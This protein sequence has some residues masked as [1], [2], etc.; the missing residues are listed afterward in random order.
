MSQNND[1]GKTVY[2]LGAG[3]S[4]ASDFKLP[5]MKGFFD[6]EHFKEG[7]EYPNLKEFLK[8]FCPNTDWPDINLEE[9]ITHLELTMEGFNWGLVD[10]ILLETRKELYKY[11]KQR[12]DDPIKGKIC[13][14]HLELF[15]Y[16]FIRSN[17][18]NY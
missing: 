5:V 17:C 18:N 12:L 11:I 4:A 1:T 7:G 15:K 9:I 10:S 14:R 8:T 13:N 3:A 16:Q 6:K 2:F